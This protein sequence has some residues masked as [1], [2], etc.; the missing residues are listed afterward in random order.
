MTNTVRPNGSY[1][2]RL[3]Q[4]IPTEIVAAYLAVHGIVATREDAVRDLILEVSAGVL[5][6]V[7]PLY[8]WRLHGVRSGFQ[9]LLTMGSFVVWV[10]AVSIPLYTRW[11]L[12]PVWGS[13]ALILWTTVIP[14]FLI[15]ERQQS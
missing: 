7:L 6:L 8:L 3:V 13:I 5:L 2:D 1:L 9:I 15:A 10:A 12:D 4:L 14:V 11:S